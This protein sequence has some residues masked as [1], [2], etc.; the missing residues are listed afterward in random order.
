MKAKRCICGKYPEVR[1]VRSREHAFECWKADCRGC[2][3]R[4]H[5]YP[6]TEEKAIELWNERVMVDRA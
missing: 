2:Y 5:G 4:I 3:R 6:K 1:F